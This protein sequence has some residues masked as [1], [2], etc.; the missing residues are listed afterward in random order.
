MTS[1]TSRMVGQ[2]A[3]S[4][5]KRQAA[6]MAAYRFFTPKI[7]DG[8]NAIFI[9]GEALVY[10][11]N[12]GVFVTPAVVRAGPCSGEIQTQGLPLVPS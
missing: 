1:P 3:Y 5:K 9:N 4:R 6:I 7:V 11:K 12:I 2:V 10:V 8:K